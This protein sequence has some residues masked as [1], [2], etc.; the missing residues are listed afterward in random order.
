[1]RRIPDLCIEI[2]ELAIGR[3]AAQ[4]DLDL[5][6]HARGEVAEHLQRPSASQCA[7]PAYAPGH[8][9]IRRTRPTRYRIRGA[10]KIEHLVL[11]QHHREIQSRARVEI[12]LHE[13]RRTRDQEPSIAAEIPFGPAH[14]LPLHTVVEKQAMNIQALVDDRYAGP[15]QRCGRFRQRKRSE[16]NTSELQSLMSI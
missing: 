8:A 9:R 10:V 4:D 14:E 13:G 1:M 11:K 3:P 6:V 16:E 12:M 15:E 5:P 7:E 2:V